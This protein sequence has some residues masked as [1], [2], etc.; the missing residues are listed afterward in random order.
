M[1]NQLQVD[2]NIQNPFLFEKSPNWG[3]SITVKSG[4][5]RTESLVTDEAAT[6]TNVQLKHNTKEPWEAKMLKIFF[7]GRI[8][9]LSS[10][11]TKWHWSQ[12]EP[13]S[14]TGDAVRDEDP[15]K[16]SSKALYPEWH[17]FSAW[18]MSEKR[19]LAW[20]DVLVLLHRCPVGIFCP[21]WHLHHSRYASNWDG[22]NSD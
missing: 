22:R 8:S 3:N 7:N 4:P 15:S 10:T 9:H 5:L 2:P 12:K 11:S 1:S 20:S 14:T 19:S 17:S 13:Q 18:E 21:A 6:V 16:I